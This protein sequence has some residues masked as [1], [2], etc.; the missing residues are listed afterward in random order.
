MSETTEPAAV[1]ADPALAVAPAAEVPAAPAALEAPTLLEA[2]TPAA[3]PTPAEA[4]PAEPTKP[5]GEPPPVVAEAPK[6][7][8]PP[9]APRTYEPFVLPE[10]VKPDAEQMAAATELFGKHNLAQEQAQELVSLHAAAMQRYAEGLAGEQHRAFADTRAQWR[11]EVMADEEIGGAGHQTA[12]KAI[13]RM[14]DLAV[15]TEQR[16]SFDQFLRVTGAGDNPAFLRMMHNFARFFDEPRVP[17]VSPQGPAPD[18]G[19]PPGRGRGQGF[20]QVMY[21]HPSSQRRTG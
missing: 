8:E 16:A 19:L 4:P 5:D 2:E 12:M 17:A 9:P 10:G 14:R 20:R 7:A 3:E 21:D 15:P 6:A 11:N 1:A 13:A 18:A